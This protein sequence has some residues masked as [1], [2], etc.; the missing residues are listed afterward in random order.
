MESRNHTKN[1]AQPKSQM[2]REPKFFLEMRTYKKQILIVAFML[3]AVVVVAQTSKGNI[4]IAGSTNMVFTSNNV[5]TVYDGVTS[6]EYKINTFSLTPEIC[7]FFIDNLAIGLSSSITSNTEKNENGDK[8][9]TSITAIGPCAYYFFPIDEKIKPFADAKIAYASTVRKS[10]PKS[11]S[12]YK[13]SSSGLAFGLGGGVFYFLTSNI[14]LGM[15]LNYTFQSSRD[16]DNEKIKLKSSGIG[17]S[18]AIALFF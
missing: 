12:D 1:G 14:S 13:D 8:V 4:Y 16:G 5:K 2:S 6:S 3:S 10:I 17:G 9:K 7:Y 18:M 11:G 15:G